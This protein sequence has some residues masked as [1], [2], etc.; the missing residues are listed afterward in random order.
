M[1]SGGGRSSMATAELVGNPLTSITRAAPLAGGVIQGSAQEYETTVSSPK[2]QT[3]FY[4]APQ[5]DLEGLNA[6]W[7]SLIWGP[8]RNL[9]S[10]ASRGYH[11]SAYQSIGREMSFEWERLSFDLMRIAS[12]EPNWDSEG[13]DAVSQ[14]AVKATT[15]LLLIARSAMEQSSFSSRPMPTLFPTA[16]G[17]VA[18]RWVHGHKEL[19]C[20]VLGDIVEVVRWS[21][22]DRFESDGFWEVPVRSVGEHLEWLLQQ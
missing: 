17:S 22:P 9:Y 5:Q 21:S 16:E 7:G 20:T 10:F 13:A 18:L 11:A 15:I 14:I 8:A 4:F 1:K 2:F 6:Y 3:P 19:K 12:L